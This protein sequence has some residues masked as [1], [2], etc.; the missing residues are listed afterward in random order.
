MGKASR[1]QVDCLQDLKRSDLLHNQRPIEFRQGIVDVGSDAADEVGFGVDQ[2]PEQV[3][4]SGVEVLG[5]SGDGF[6]P[7]QELRVRCGSDTEA[8]PSRSSVALDRALDEGFDFV[9]E[10]VGSEPEVAGITVEDAHE[11]VGNHIPVCV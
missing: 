3:V 6:V 10:E 9:A 11:V 4:Q 5:E 1:H 8:D 2:R 7:V